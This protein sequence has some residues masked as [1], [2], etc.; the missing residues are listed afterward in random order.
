[1]IATD[2]PVRTDGLYR[3]AK[4]AMLGLGRTGASSSNGSGDYVIAFSTA[5]EL[6]SK[7]RSDNLTEGGTV[8][9]QGDLSPLFQATIEATEEAIY[10]SLLKAVDVVGKNGRR[11][12]ALPIDRVL[13]IKKKYNR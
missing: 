11:R 8:M 10:N 9:R 13:E 3:I 7:H 12:D 5:P 6:R 4:R 2:A 1:V